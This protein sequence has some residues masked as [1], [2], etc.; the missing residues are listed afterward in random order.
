MGLL[1]IPRRENARRPNDLTLERVHQNFKV[2]YSEKSAS[3]YAEKNHDALMKN[4][5]KAQ[6]PFLPVKIKINLKK[7]KIKPY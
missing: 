2:F 7:K 3:K 5:I 1:L 6:N 4:K